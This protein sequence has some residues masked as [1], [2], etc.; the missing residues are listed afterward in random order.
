MTDRTRSLVA[1]VLLFTALA[2]GVLWWQSSRSRSELEAQ[3]LLQAEQRSLHL[4]D[5]MAGQ[6]QGVFSAVDL[7]L[8]Q[9]RTEWPRGN[10]AAFGQR[11]QETLQALPEGFVSH[12]V[13]A[14]AEGLVVYNSL[15]LGQ[16][17]NIADRDYF[18]AHL[19]GGDR[20][21]IGVPVRSRL[22]G[23]W[24]FARSRPLLRGGRFAGPVHL[25]LGA[26]PM[27]R[28]LA[29]LEL[30]R[31]DVVALI[32]PGGRVLA[33]SR[34]NEGSMA[35]SMPNDRPYMAQPDAHQGVYRTPGKVDG[36]PR[37]YG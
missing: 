8:R 20:L 14:N 26:E 27:A 7:A 17:V 31:Q 19:A 33:R 11:V 22:D 30:S 18:R 4:A 10:T 25:T 32:H 23:R 34:D 16:G 37:T 24:V 12:A 2:T 35:Q 36:V 6:V 28:K 15:G 29:G 5:A 13:V 21:A 9:L 3:V 1:L